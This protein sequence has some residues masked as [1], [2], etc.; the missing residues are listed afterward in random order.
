MAN[1]T[2]KQHNLIKN[3]QGHYCSICEKQWK[4]KPRKLCP[5][6]KL[7]DKTDDLA[8]RNEPQDYFISKNIKLLDLVCCYKKDKEYIYLYDPDGSSEPYFGDLPEILDPWFNIDHQASIPDCE[9]LYYKNIDGLRSLNL[10]KGDKTT[11]VACYW[12]SESRKFVN[13]YNPYDCIILDANLPTR[14]NS[15][16]DLRRQFPPVIREE[17]LKF[18][19]LAIPNKSLAVGVV[20]QQKD[21][22]FELSY[23]YL[24]DDC[25]ILDHSLPQVFSSQNDL[26]QEYPNAIAENYLSMCNLKRPESKLSI[27]VVWEYKWRYY[28]QKSDCEILDISLPTVY[29]YYSQLFDKFGEVFTPEELIKINLKPKEKAIAVGAI[30]SGLRDRF[31]LYYR[32]ADCE[33]NDPTLPEIYPYPPLNLFTEKEL[34]RFNKVP[35]DTP[36]G[37]FYDAYSN[38]H[39]HWFEYLYDP[40]QCQDQIEFDAPIYVLITQLPSRQLDNGQGHASI[41]ACFPEIPD[42]LQ[43]AFIWSAKEPL[44]EVKENAQARGYFW[45]ESKFLELY[46]REDLQYHDRDILL[47]KAKLK[48]IYHL[49]K[50]FFKKLGKPDQ[51]AENPIN[52]RYAPVKQYWRSR[53]EQFLKDNAYAYAQHLSRYNYYLEIFIANKE[54]MAAGRARKKAQKEALGKDGSRIMKKF[55]WNAKSEEVIEQT[56]NCLQC[57]CSIMASQGFLC[58]VHSYGL[59]PDQ[60]PCPDFTP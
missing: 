25:E 47:S 9:H 24:P 7:V 38:N 13:L 60:F 43:S 44:V 41:P 51:L 31:E 46:S 42:Y 59:S 39:E 36:Q 53:V 57:K 23:Y 40:C 17:F 54:A 50:S 37:A 58:T 28:F 48:Q 5:G 21:S 26:F 33:I 2:F 1:P 16:N 29:Q 52:E 14:F 12:R 55:N 19:N 11:P 49:P 8:C 27:G 35:S 15:E 3:D 30:W 10:K 56:I 6:A 4:G 18:W 45:H 34:K 20:W 32:K 22:G